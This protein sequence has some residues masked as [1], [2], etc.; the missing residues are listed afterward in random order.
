VFP[1]ADERFLGHVF[2]RTGIP[3]DG[4]RQSEHLAL[5]APDERDAGRRIARRQPREDRLV[6]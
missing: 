2:R 6:G 3:E 4:E 5:E 1:H